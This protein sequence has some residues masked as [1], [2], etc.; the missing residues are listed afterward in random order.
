[1]IFMGQTVFRLKN[2]FRNEEKLSY[3]SQRNLTAFIFSTFFPLLLSLLFSDVIA[4]Y[5][6]LSKS[7][8]LFASLAA[9]AGVWLVRKAIFN[10]LSWITRDKNT[11]RLVERISYNHIIISV[12][13]AF[14]L[15]TA[16]FLLPDI[17]LLVQLKVLICCSLLVYVLFLI[18]S[19]QIIITNHYS[20]FFIILYLCTL[21]FLPTA[22]FA[23]YILSL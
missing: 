23:N 22:L 3:T 18:R 21:E 20:H 7:G 6:P 19:Y 11:F 15:M 10:F 1:M 5:I 8:V 14:P 13:L 2:Q 12:L 17:E 4:D 16:M 9:M